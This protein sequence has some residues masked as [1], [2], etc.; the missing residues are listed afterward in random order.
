MGSKSEFT[1]ADFRYT[2]RRGNLFRSRTHLSVARLLDFLNRDYEYGRLV[3]ND[4]IIHE[5]FSTPESHIMVLVDEQD[6][7]RYHAIKKIFP[8]DK[9][10]ALGHPRL[11]SRVE[12]LDDIVVFDQPHEASSIFLEDPSFSFDYAHILPLVEKCSILHGHTSTVMVEL[13][14]RAR[15]GMLVDFSDAKRLVRDVVRIFDHKFFINRRYVVSEDDTHYKIAFDGPKGSFELQVPAHTTYLLQGEATV[16]NL[17][18]EIIKLLTPKLPHNVEG[19]GVY[20]YEGYNK[21][22]HI[23]SRTL[24]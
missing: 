1:D 21:G 7:A 13:V 24:R 12:E 10:L 8:D 20:V 11:V 23:V 22:S 9:V 19:V 4:P 3:S 5:D 2:D 15:Q 14:G 18:T 17:S 16:E 6:I